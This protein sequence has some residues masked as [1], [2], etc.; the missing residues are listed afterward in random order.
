MRAEQHESDRSG[1]ML[2]LEGQQV[3]TL[4]RIRNCR[5]SVS[6]VELLLFAALVSTGAI[7]PLRSAAEEIRSWAD[8]TGQFKRDALFQRID[9]DTVILKSAQGKIL[10]IPLDRLSSA[11]QAYAK[12]AAERG[13][14]SD[15]FETAEE[16]PAPSGQ[17]PAVSVNTPE[18][19]IR[20]VVAQGVGRTV[21]DAKK[22][23]YREAV[24][25]VVGAY[26][27]GDTL[28]RNDE[29]IEDKV[30]AL[31]GALVQKADVI[32][33]SVTTSG[34][35]TRLRI[36]AEIKVT[37]VMKSLAMINITSTAV[38]TS[39]IAAQVT[40]TAD[41]AQAAEAMLGD[42]R[43]WETF[44]ASF[45]TM[46]AVGQPK[47]L[48]A[49]GDEATVE[50]L[51][52]ISPDT[53]KYLAFA[54]RLTAILS[55]LGGPS[56]AFTID[57]K[58]PG[59]D[60][61][62]RKEDL[63]ELWR[64]VLV[65]SY[66]RGNLAD[67]EIA[68]AFREDARE[69]LQ[70]YFKDMGEQIAV[71]SGCLVY[72]FNQDAGR[73]PHG[74]GLA[75]VAPRWYE[76]IGRK[77]DEL[78]IV[79]LMT[80]ANETYSRTKWEWFTCEQSLFSGGAESPW[81]RSIECEITVCASGGK[82]IASEIVPLSTGFG[83]SRDNWEYYRPIVMLGPMWI[84]ANGEVQDRSAYVSQFTF[85]RRTELSTNEAASITHVNCV[86]RPRVN[87]PH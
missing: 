77:R 23:A 62:R 80:Q 27:E 76:A 63:A 13:S 75:E 52:R 41:Q 53:E 20:T 47:V 84:E 49:R 5:R 1:S 43:M 61:R 22:D 71:K 40:T 87:N 54:K 56:G 38:R 9:G 59:R 15:P 36:R 11:D 25:Q 51:V 60:P 8:A 85:P 57:G 17:A 26:I 48:K 55:K 7:L 58:T 21:D 10:R 16:S 29:L 3:G 39:D 86:V 78:M 42:A 45:F 30:L 65:S 2:R 28:T 79:C 83:V 67:P 37:E 82:E 64:H 72:C 81:N 33:E 68:Y 35:L 12:E 73:Q 31:S 74:C 14:G 34:G 70:G 46:T 18:G 4:L 50:V 32:P 69:D 66:H 19:A 6:P 24:R 44:P